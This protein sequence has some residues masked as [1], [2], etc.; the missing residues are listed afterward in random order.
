MRLSGDD[1]C[2]E[3]DM[4]EFHECVANRHGDWTVNGKQYFLP[5]SVILD[6]IKTNN[7]RPPSAQFIEHL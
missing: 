7:I 2:L 4:N 6:H 3:V 5:I 1:S